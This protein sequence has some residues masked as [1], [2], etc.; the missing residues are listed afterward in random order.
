MIR[1]SVIVFAKIYRT[2]VK[3]LPM[4]LVGN[5]SRNNPFSRPNEPRVGKLPILL[6][7]VCFSP[8]S[9]LV[10]E[11]PRSFLLKIYMDVH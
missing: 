7:F 5:H 1:N 11:I 2:S 8:P 10:T 4:E 9:F 3:A 6:I